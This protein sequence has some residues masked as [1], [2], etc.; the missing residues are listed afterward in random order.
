PIYLIDGDKCT[1]C[2]GFFDEPQCIS[3]CPVDCITTDPDNIES[4]EELKYKLK[5]IETEA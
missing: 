4:V 3:V 1:E 2:V 5:Q